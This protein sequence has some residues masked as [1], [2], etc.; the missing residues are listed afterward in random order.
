MPDALQELKERYGEES[1]EGYVRLMKAIDSLIFMFNEFQKA[2]IDSPQEA[3]LRNQLDRAMEATRNRPEHAVG[4]IEGM[5]AIIVS[6][7]AGAPYEQ[8]FTELGIEPRS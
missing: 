2:E 5:V 8:W 4:L 3:M 1:A 6:M 7:R